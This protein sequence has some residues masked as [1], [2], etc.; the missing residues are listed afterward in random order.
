[1]PPSCSTFNN[2][3][4]IRNKIGNL[5]GFRDDIYFSN[6]HKKAF[7]TFGLPKGQILD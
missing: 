1:M 4:T 5:A 6:A 7:A 2:H 3:G